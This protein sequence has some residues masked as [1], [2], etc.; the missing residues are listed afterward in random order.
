MKVF[1]RRSLLVMGK[2]FVFL[3]IQQSLFGQS[4]IVGRDDVLRQLQLEGKMGVGSSF[5]ARPF[6]ADAAISTDSIYRLVDGNIERVSGGKLI[7]GKYGRWEV[8][9]LTWDNQFTSHHPYGWNQTDMIQARGLE[10]VLGVGAF[11]SMGVLSVQL[12]PEFAYAAN[13]NFAHSANYGASTKGA[14][15]HFFPGQSSVRLNLGAVSL[16][17]STENIWWGPGM[18]NSLLMSNNAPGFLHLTLNSRKP[19]KTPIGSFEW[20]FVS[21]KLTE[22]TT[23]LLENKNLTTS[24]YNPTTY[25]GSGYSG[26]YD[27]AQKWRYFN[28][29][30]ITYQPKWAKGLFLGVNRVAYAYYDG[31]KNG[32]PGFVVSYLPS[33]SGVFRQTYAYGLN[34]P[35][36]SKRYKQMASVHFRYLFA[37]AHAEIYGEYGWG[38][39]Q[40]NIRDFLLNPNHSRAFI[41]GF[42]KFMPLAKNRW[43]D[44]QFEMTQMAQ[45]ASYIMRTAGNWYGYQ[46][47]Y[48]NQGRILGAG[49]G[50]GNNVQSFSVS[51]VEGLTRLGMKLEK[52]E[53]DPVDYSVSWADMLVGFLGQKRFGKILVSGEVQGVVSSGYLWLVG[54]SAFNLHCVLKGVYRF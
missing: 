38:D 44:W 39:N 13:P 19:L 16:G 4:L 23:V 26:P 31:I 54:N 47:G 21:G 37:K 2:L 27:P 42:R 3:G 43:L 46:G 14:Y 24:Y 40:Y 35:G 29:L 32:D 50:M 12:N 11:A 45:T 5:C 22:D 25:D 10:S 49:L 41:T 51:W 7:G 18:N 8:L 30:T 17:V 36:G 48:T 53:H 15:H 28:G 1:D 34:L 6:F 33:I 9:P 52:L 20:Q